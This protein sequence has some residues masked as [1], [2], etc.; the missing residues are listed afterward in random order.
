MNDG[1]NKSK[2]SQNLDTLQMVFTLFVFFS[3][4]LFATK[5]TSVPAA[6][7]FRLVIFLIGI[8]GSIVVQILKRRA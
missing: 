3:G 4:Y 2:K 5:P 6:I 7:T 8:I 1:E